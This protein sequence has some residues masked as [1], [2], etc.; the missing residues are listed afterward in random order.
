MG[1]GKKGSANSE[2]ILG[3]YRWVEFLGVLE[4]GFTTG[5]VRI[6]KI[7]SLIDYFCTDWI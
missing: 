4:S 3:E 2:D 7:C 6:W 5:G 1:Q